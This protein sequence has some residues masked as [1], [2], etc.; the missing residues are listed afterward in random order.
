MSFLCVLIKMTSHFI[1]VYIHICGKCFGWLMAITSGHPPKNRMLLIWTPHT[2]SRVITKFMCFFFGPQNSIYGGGPPVFGAPASL[3][4]LGAGFTFLS[5]SRATVF[6]SAW[7][8]TQSRCASPR[9]GNPWVFVGPAEVQPRWCMFLYNCPVS[10]NMARG[11]SQWLSENWIWRLMPRG[12]H[13]SHWNTLPETTSE[14][15]SENQRLEFDESSVPG[16][17]PS[18]DA[19]QKSKKAEVRMLCCTCSMWM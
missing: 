14:F 1:D 12:L 5:F 16:G 3:F 19:K 9:C 2:H 10:T 6:E 18:Q 7:S 17:S 15:N 4:I 8:T 13:I 11:K